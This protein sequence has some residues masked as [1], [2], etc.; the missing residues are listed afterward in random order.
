MHSSTLSL[1]SVLDGVGGQRQV[2]S[3]LLL[4]RIGYPLYRRLGG[5][6]CL[7]ARVPKN[8]PPPEFDPR[9]VQPVASRNT[10][11]TFPAHTVEVT[12]FN[13]SFISGK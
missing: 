1:T 5:F 4:E 8:L 3:A 10:D 2:P 9:T 6:Y 7:S 13:I 12:P 11:Y